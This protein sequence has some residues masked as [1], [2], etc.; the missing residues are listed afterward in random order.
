VGTR[1]TAMASFFDF[2]GRDSKRGGGGGGGGDDFDD[3]MEELY[4]GDDMDDDITRM[5]LMESAHMSGNAA[6]QGDEMW[7]KQLL[8]RDFYNAFDDDFKDNE[9]D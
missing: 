2:F 7:E 3:D 1:N 5:R 9:L 6:A 4:G 8:H